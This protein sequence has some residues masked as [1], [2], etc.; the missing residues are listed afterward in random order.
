MPRS[1]CGGQVAGLATE[2]LAGK[3]R[4]G[5]GFLG[6]GIDAEL[7]SGR[8]GG[9]RHVMAQA[10]H[11]PAVAQTSAG[12]DDFIRLNGAKDLVHDAVRGKFRGGQKPRQPEPHRLRRH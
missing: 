5:D 7:R 6:V 10:A 2:R 4:E 8:D 11:Q 12:D 3:H 1:R 9:V